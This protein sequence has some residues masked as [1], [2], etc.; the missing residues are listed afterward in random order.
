M[1]AVAVGDVHMGVGFDGD[2]R[3]DPVGEG[4]GCVYGQGCID[5]DSCVGTV[6]MREFCQ[7]ESEIPLWVVDGYPR[8]EINVPVEGRLEG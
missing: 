2:G 1:I 7:R 8:C 3:G 4:V 5:R 6:D